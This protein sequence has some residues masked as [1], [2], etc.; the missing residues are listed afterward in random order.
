MVVA[1]RLVKAHA[2]LKVVTRPPGA[3]VSVDKKLLGTTPLLADELDA[4]TGADVA[5]T[6]AGYDPVHVSVELAIGKTA[7]VDET[8]KPAQRYGTIDLAV[9]NG[10]GD[11]YF[12]GAK[13]GTT[14]VTHALRLRLP[15]GAQTLHLVNTGHKPALEWNVTCEVSDTETRKC[16]T[17]RP[18]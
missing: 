11:V 2:A 18:G 10:W 6:L 12:K 16:T 9:T 14:S 3:Q 8:L 17:K 5:I 7:L 4:A 15:V 13:I 1:P